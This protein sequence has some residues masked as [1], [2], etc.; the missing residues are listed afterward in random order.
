MTAKRYI[1]LPQLDCVSVRRRRARDAREASENKRLRIEKVQ[2]MYKK[3]DARAGLSFWLSKLVAFL[4]SS[5][6]SPSRSML[7]LSNG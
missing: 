3:R 4:P 2:E 6:P 1:G 7:T 5:L